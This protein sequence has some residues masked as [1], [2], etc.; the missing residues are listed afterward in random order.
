MLKNYVLISNKEMF[1]VSLK[2][3][4]DAENKKEAYNKKVCLL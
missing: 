3:A 4:F 1:V 2:S